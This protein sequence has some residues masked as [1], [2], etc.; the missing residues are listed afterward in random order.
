[1]Y[2]SCDDSADR[3]TGFQK[4][5]YCYVLE[6]FDIVQCDSNVYLYDAFTCFGQ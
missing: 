3:D 2:V 4:I 5:K 6:W 1:V